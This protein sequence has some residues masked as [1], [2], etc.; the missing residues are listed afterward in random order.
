MT[1]DGFEGDEA[2][3]SISVSEVVGITFFPGTGI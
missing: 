2:M 3:V 1:E